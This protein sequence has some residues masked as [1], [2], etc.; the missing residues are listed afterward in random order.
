VLP[1]NVTRRLHCFQGKAD[2]LSKLPARLRGYQSWIPPDW[3]VIVLVDEDRDDCTRLK[4]Q[5][6][7]AARHA[8]LPT[9]SAVRG[10][11]H[12]HV[13][14]RIAVEELE[15]WFF[16]DVEALATAYPGVPTSL[17][18]RAKFRDPDAITGGTWEALEKVLQ[19]AGYFA[20]GLPKIEVARTIGQHLDP[21][22]NQSRSF[23]SFV[24][25]LR[26]CLP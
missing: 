11:R 17:S 22:R 8:N 4:Q 14:N 5:L 16:G 6:E 3:R 20:A 26:A 1:D 15:A 18:R 2:L 21:S 12:F 9:K 13:V 23:R 7:H 25:G 19:S 10:H 24:A